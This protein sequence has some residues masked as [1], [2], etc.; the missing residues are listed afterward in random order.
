MT[1]ISSATCDQSFATC[2]TICHRAARNTPRPRCACCRAASLLAVPILPP[3]AAEQSQCDELSPNKLRR[4]VVVSRALSD[5]RDLRVLQT[6]GG[7]AATVA[8]E[9]AHCEQTATHEDKKMEQKRRSNRSK[10]IKQQPQSATSRNTKERTQEI[11]RL[12]P[13]AA[14]IATPAQIPVAIFQADCD[15]AAADTAKQGRGQR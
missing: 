7:F 5:V 13:T 1:I 8:V 2:E 6:D 9:I 11:T 15:A 14:K 10:E 12:Q 4:I 3:R